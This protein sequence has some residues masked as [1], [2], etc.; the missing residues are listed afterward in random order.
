[1]M[2]EHDIQNSIRLAISENKLGVSFRTNVGRAWTGEKI[3]KNP[4][5]SIT[6]KNPRPFDTGLPKGFSDLLVIKTLTITPDM[7]G[8]QIASANFIEVKNKKGKPTADQENFIERMQE[9]G[10]KAGIARSPD[11]ALKILRS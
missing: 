4:D 5:K 10:A 3:T 11:D 1:M 9:L 8:K 7:V 6:I 2:L